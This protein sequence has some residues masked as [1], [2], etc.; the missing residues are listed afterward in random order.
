MDLEVLGRALKHSR[1]AAGLSQAEA[2]DAIGIN[3]VVL[4]Y[5]EAGTR[6]APLTTV[7]ALARLYGTTAAAL[8]SGAEPAVLDGQHRQMAMQT[9]FRAAPELTEKHGIG[10]AL[11]LRYVTAYEELLRDLDQPLPGKGQSPFAP[12]RGRAYRRD[13]ARLARE[14]RQYLGVG[15]GPVGDLWRLVDDHVL[16]F[17]L[18]LGD[19]ASAPSGFFCNHPAVGFCIVVNTTPHR[20]RQL[21]TLAHELAHTFFHSQTSDAIVSLDQASS[22]LNETFANM[23]ASEFLVPADGLAR[24]MDELEAWEKVAD[25]A[26][27]IHLHQR[28]GVSYEMMLLRLRSEKMIKEDEYEKLRQVS[29]T[30]LAR[31]LGYAPES[32]VSTMTSPLDALPYRMLRLVRTALDRELISVG[33][34]AETLG[35]SREDIMRLDANPAADDD[36][37]ARIRELEKV[38]GFD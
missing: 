38:F 32:D 19:L 13:A 21:F 8:I 9:L 36:Q 29:P 1:D 24:A 30:K 4:A 18:A 6:Q 25:A 26:T 11:F 16:V 31:A 15:S 12:L 2:A 7:S 37:K 17:R 10:S 28:F 23:F 33:D 35:V 14:V 3:R 20:G 5:Y 27:V 34:A 22:Q